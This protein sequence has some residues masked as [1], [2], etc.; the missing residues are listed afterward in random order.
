[1]D[2]HDVEKKKLCFS[3]PGACRP[4]VPY[5]ASTALVHASDARSGKNLIRLAV[6]T[7]MKCSECTVR[8]GAAL[9]SSALIRQ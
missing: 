8:D 3:L 7:Y 5:C 1:M 4:R 9:L 2:V 6:D